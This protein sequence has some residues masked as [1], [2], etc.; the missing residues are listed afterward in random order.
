MVFTSNDLMAIF[1]NQLWLEIPEQEQEHTWQLVTKQLYSNAAA[2]WNA[3]LNTLCLN[4]FLAWFQD[5]FDNGDFQLHQEADLSIWEV[6]NGTFINFGETRIVLIPDDKSNISEFCIPQEWVDI[7]NWVPDYYLAVQL[8][9]E[10][11]WLRVWGYATR[12]QIRE[13][14]RYEVISRSY[15]LDAEDLIPNINIM[16]V[17]Q[18]F[19]PP[20]KPEVQFLPSLL[21]SQVEKLLEQLSYTT[22]YSPRLDAPFPEWAAIVASD[23]YRQQLYHLRIENCNQKI[24]ESSQAVTG[25][26]LSLWFQNI[27]TAG[28]QSLDALFVLEQ[29]DFAFNFRS[30]SLFN[31][32]IKIKG[33]KLIDLGMQLREKSVV[34][35]LGLTR[36]ADEKVCIRARLCPTTG[37][38]YLPANMKLVLL[39]DSGTVLQE[40]CS[41]SHDNY[42]QLKRFKPLQGTRFSI[43]VSL[44]NVSIKENFVLEEI[45]G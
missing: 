9:L 30:N 37:E 4:S 10:E 44:G 6:V 1:P 31:S 28:W 43:K 34:L 24:V 45:D 41:R 18:E 40:V 2:R 35:L 16:W 8:N 13:Q 21:P 42:I 17:A 27:F 32:E 39:S 14:A 11:C 25:S 23:E 3:Y 36:E 26:N 33:V 7:T 19:C 12:T 15:C 38:N 29:R 22:S 5:D 20:Q